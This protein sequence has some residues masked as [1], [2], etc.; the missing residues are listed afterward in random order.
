M[1][2]QYG[3]GQQYHPSG[4]PGYGG[5]GNPYGGAGMGMPGPMG[6]GNPMMGG[7]DQGMSY[8]QEYCKLFVANVVLTNQIKELIA[9][10]NEL[11][12]R[13]A[14]LE[15][16]AVPQKQTPVLPAAKTNKLEASDS[17]EDDGQDKKR[18]VRRTASEI[19]K[20][21]VCP[22]Q[23]CQKG[24]GSEGALIQHVRLKH[25]ELADG[26]KEK[27]AKASGTA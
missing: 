10:K 13:L 2:G 12:S 9:E 19:E 5:Q 4:Y 20:N 18:R 3:N 24:Y 25:P 11:V 6:G 1:D 27:L 21:F 7:D 26:I 23:T 17:K 15:T 16:N 22:A 8:Y 14:K